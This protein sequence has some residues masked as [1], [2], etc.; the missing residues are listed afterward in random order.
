[1]KRTVLTAIL[2]MALSGCIGHMSELTKP[3]EGWPKLTITEHQGFWTTFYN[4]AEVVPIAVYVLVGP[5]LGCAIINLNRGTCKVYYMARI[6][7]E[8][9]IEHCEGRDHAGDDSLAKGWRDY[10]SN[11]LGHAIVHGGIATW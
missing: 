1:M 9:E 8:G 10:K 11:L 3:A 2:T 6:F 5:P 7:R 4:C